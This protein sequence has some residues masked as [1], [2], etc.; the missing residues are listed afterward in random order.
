MYID[1]PLVFKELH[2]TVYKCRTVH[3][4]DLLQSTKVMG[5][6]KYSVLY[7]ELCTETYMYIE[8]RRLLG[9]LI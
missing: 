1:I 3:V 7:K 2:Y 8:M 4:G 6:I 5:I 9:G